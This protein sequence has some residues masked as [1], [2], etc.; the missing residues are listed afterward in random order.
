MPIDPKAGRRGLTSIRAIFLVNGATLG[1]WAVQVPFIVDR[2][3]ITTT[4]MGLLILLM[5]IGAIAAMGLSGRLIGKFGSR[6]V[7]R[8]VAPACALSLLAVVL[9]PDLAICAAAIGALGATI[10]IMDVAAN[11]NAVELEEQLGRAIL[12]NTHGFWSV[13]GFLGGAL[14]GTLIAAFGAAGLAMLVSALTIAVVELAGRRL[15]A[16]PAPPEQAAATAEAGANGLGQQAAGVYV[17]GVMALLSFVPESA[18]LDWSALFL[19]SNHGTGVAG[20]GL[21]FG[22]FSAAMAAMRF[23]GDALRN[24]IGAAPLLFAS[25]LTGAGGLA[26]VALAPSAQ[27]ALAGFAMTGVGLANMVPVIFAAAGRQGRANPGAAIAAVSVVGYGGMLV[28]PSVLGLVAER[29]GFTACFLGLAAL[30]MMVALQSG[31][32]APDG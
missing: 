27:V 5:G 29:V 4:A 32:V 12:S 31:R 16:P 24:R 10:A 30:L 3:G 6:A 1:S 23:C 14:G 28:A 17:L 22:L 11:A 25:G 15:Q 20:L 18:V 8:A 21:A 13:G 19:S 26:V 7:L 2:H 9:A